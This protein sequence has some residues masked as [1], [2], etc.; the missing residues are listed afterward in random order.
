M[1]IETAKY[2]LA[3][4]V[5]LTEQKLA[6]LEGAEALKALETAIAEYEVAVFR[7]AIDLA[8]PWMLL[9]DAHLQAGNPQAAATAYEQS[10]HITRVNLGLFT[11][12]QLDAVHRQAAMF[13]A[14]GDKDAATDREEYALTLQ[15]R[16]FAPQ[17]ELVPALR[18]MGDWYMQVSKPAKA[19]RMYNE[20]IHLLT[21]STDAEP[22]LLS[23][24]YLGVAESYLLERFP[25]QGFYQK[26]ERNFSWQGADPYSSRWDLARGMF[27]GP[28]NRAL[29]RAEEILRPQAAESRDAK[30]QLSE[31]LVRLGDLN[32]LFEKWSAATAW[33]AS[34]FDLW[35]DIDNAGGEVADAAVLEMW[36]EQPVPLHL[37]L[38]TE[39]GQVND[40]PPERIDVGHITLAFSLSS[41]GKVGRI[42]TVEMHPSELRDIRFKRML[43]EAR[44]R[45]QIEQG[46]A[47]RAEK[48]VHRHEFLYV[49]KEDV[50][51][52][53]DQPPS[54]SSAASDDA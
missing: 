52:D 36:F 11:P 1:P 7:D 20:A 4:A 34:V 28:A 19:R 29:L 12:E 5:S 23:H 33:Y 25:R 44:Y 31:I 21:Q 37:P 49:V 8:G 35:S 17:S 46:I 3:S 22:S 48:V 10:I 47:V 54:T 43:R 39:I 27:Y 40:Y 16:K 9:G 2:E 53:R 13:D 41:H 14:I 50:K 18:R 45:P 51:E 38:P 15:R 32:M 24:T 6:S 30:E 42:E 26:E